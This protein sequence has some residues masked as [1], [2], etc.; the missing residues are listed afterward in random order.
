MASRVGKLSKGAADY[1]AKKVYDPKP[2]ADGSSMKKSATRENIVDAARGGIYAY[3]TIYEGLEK[4]A[5]QIGNSLKNESVA[6]VKH[7]YGSE[8]GHTYEESMSAAGNAAM[9]YMN[10]QSLGVKGFLKKTAKSTGKNVAKNVISAH[11]SPTKTASSAEP[12]VEASD[13]SAAPIAPPRKGK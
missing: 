12:S 13:N 1:L 7:Q 2:A 3:A 4:S 10:I 8:A 11:G 9:T 5:K 6:V